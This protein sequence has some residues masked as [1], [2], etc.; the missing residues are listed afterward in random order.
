MRVVDLR[1]GLHMVPTGLWALPGAS[2]AKTSLDKPDGPGTY[3]D[4]LKGWLLDGEPAFVDVGAP[5]DELPQERAIGE[6][7]R[8]LFIRARVRRLVGHQFWFMLPSERDAT[9][10]NQY[11]SKLRAAFEAVAP[12]GATAHFI[13]EP[14]ATAEYF[15]LV[16]GSL[17]LPKGRNSLVLIVDCGALTCNITLAFST[18]AGTFGDLGKGTGR[19]RGA[20]A[21][22]HSTTVRDRAGRHADAILLGEMQDALG[23][24]C[25]DL[26][27]SEARRLA[28]RLKIAA[29][30]SP[31]GSA[32]IRAPDGQAHVLDR[33]RLADLSAELWSQYQPLLDDVLTSAHQQLGTSETHGKVLKDAGVDGPGDLH[34]VLAAIVLSGGTSQLPGFEEE[35]RERLGVADAVPVLRPKGAYPGV[36]ALGAMARLLETRRRL[37]VVGQADDPGG[38]TVD[39]GRDLDFVP[40][41]DAN[42]FLRWQA[43]GGQT[44]AINLLTPK[45]TL[46]ALEEHGVQRDI[47]KGAR[48]S[49][50]RFWLSHDQTGGGRILDGHQYRFSIP[51]LG[52]NPRVTARLRSSG[53]ELALTFQGSRAERLLNAYPEGLVEAAGVPLA[54]PE[55]GGENARLW[56]AKDE[57]AVVDIGMSKSLLVLADQDAFVS[58]DTF[59]F[60]G[61]EAQQLP[62]PVGWSAG[63]ATDAPKREDEA[64]PSRPTPPNDIVDRPADSAD[65]APQPPQ[66]EQPEKRTHPAPEPAPSPETVVSEPE[67]GR[68]AQIASP[69]PDDPVFGRWESESAFLREAHGRLKEGGF[70]A[71][72]SD[73]VALHV[74][75]KLRPLVLLAGPPGAGKTT[76]ARA[77]ARLL[78]LGE[79]YS[80]WEKVAIEAHWTTGEQLG[81]LHKQVRIA[82]RR[83]N[84]LF[85]LL[86]DEFN[87]TRPE[88]YFG[89][90]LSALESGSSVC[91]KLSLP[92]LGPQ[93]RMLFFGTLNVDETSRPPSDKVLDRAF[94]IELEPR[95]SLPASLKRPSFSV[96]NDCPAVDAATWASWG[97]SPDS[98]A[99]PGELR[100][101]WEAF[102]TVRP[103][104][105]HEDLTPSRRAAA[106]VCRFMHH[107]E[108]L[109]LEL[110][111]ADAI[112]RAV[113]ARIL[114]RIRGEAQELAP[115]LEALS[116]LFAPGENDAW[117]RCRRITAALQSQISS[118][119]VSYW[120]G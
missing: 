108:Q 45:N 102:G 16:Q 74:A 22:L 53:T 15:R 32:A 91:D 38:D 77:Y 117:A 33:S 104:S 112:D 20:L 31:D 6:F 17:R 67:S 56:T 51:N 11:K 83:K 54:A 52:K 21:S 4:N 80:T 85:G 116:E 43:P 106:D 109:D 101:V 82:H 64:Q 89:R 34:K 119:W 7:V 46:E 94:L 114:P 75:A 69:T 41:R 19:K 92:S 118:G 57:V 13:D 99:V 25:S 100:D 59:A 55:K 50:T 71:E 103:R 1:D 86:L 42:I 35:L 72:L 88:Y 27:S 18:V 95:R 37:T 84:L 66:K 105:V 48:G 30:T 76:L 90:T 81:A 113:A 98:I 49:G 107:I 10:R 70:D 44:G 87:L 93:H 115:L 111:R 97:D 12:D 120:G 24:A 14:D 60:L 8:H 36:P 65:A 68:G 2:P 79:D 61:K 3:V 5:P 78:G 63:E 96:L 28:E 29:A 62:L 73:L 40:G 58:H 47:S 9:V 110:S 26:G 23:S 39:A